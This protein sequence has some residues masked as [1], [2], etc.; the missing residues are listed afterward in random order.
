VSKKTGQR[1]NAAARNTP[2]ARAA[3][4]TPA[5]AAGARGAAGA[6]TA[7][8]R[9]NAPA[10]A[11]RQANA[12]A[13]AGRPS[14]TGRRAATA[15]DEASAAVERLLTR[16]LTAI[17]AGDPLTAELETSTFMSIP[18]ATGKTDPDQV[19][20]FISKV[21]VDGAVRMRTPDSAA[22][23]RLLTS[24]GS[25]ATRRAASQ[26][27]GRLT[28]A[29]VY[30]PDWVTEAGKAVPGRA[31]RRYDV[32]GDHEAVAVTFSYGEAEHAIVAQVDLTGMPTAVM[33]GV[34][35]DP[36]DV[37][38]GMTRD[39]GELERWESISLAEARGRL[40]EP[41]ARCDDDPEAGT[42]AETNVFLPV[43]RSRVR[44]LPADV[45][46]PDR[47]FGAHQRAAAVDDFMRSPLAAEAVAADE[48]ATRFWAEVLTG[49]SGRVID[50]PPA[51]VGP[52]KLTHMLL[53]HVPNT[54][55]L[56]PAQRQHLEP[57][58]T[59]WTRWSAAHR[60]LDD[61]ATAL[62]T[63]RLPW[64]FSRFDQAYDD[65]YA[66]LSRSYMADVAASDADVS[67]LT[68]QFA[69]RLFVLPITE[70]GDDGALPD[71]GDPQTRSALTEAEFADCTPPDDMTREE[72][73]TAVHRVISEIW[74]GDPFD[75]FWSAQSLVADGLDR[76]DAI[77]VLAKT[78]ATSSDR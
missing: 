43:A 33:V 68:E 52:R 64:V 4:K 57:A 58:V 41:L 59:A 5:T 25:P 78:A 23:L 50:E 16:L 1:R 63:E 76:H 69:R 75:T 24:L 40:E 2:A 56:T 70:P 67:W 48:D 73:M 66:A 47:I 71:A 29:G 74:E 38:E 42:G 15:R 12:P 35:P 13:S 77:H 22:L 30:P 31:W 28:Q 51:Q 61:Q 46:R 18:N 60:G 26:G 6:T 34:T 3:G 27:L 20:A 14:G 36:A 21:M 37:I 9:G 32:F 44:R 19:E 10:G 11:G 7:A 49:Y 65:P 39:D 54:F 53:G 45:P 72:F 17:A 55:T 8:P 62:L